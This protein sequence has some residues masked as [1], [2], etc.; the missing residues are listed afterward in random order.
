M[1]AADH[2]VLLLG[3]PGA[4]VVGRI[5]GALLAGL[6]VQ[7]AFQRFRG[8]AV[9]G[10]LDQ[11]LCSLFEHPDNPIEHCGIGGGL[12]K[13]AAGQALKSREIPSQQT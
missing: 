7:F 3:S 11:S 12:S 13:F 1:L 4:D 9:P 8:R 10:R 5:T 6:A 2:L